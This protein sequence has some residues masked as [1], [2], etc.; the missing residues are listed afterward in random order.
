MAGGNEA[1]L[2]LLSCVQTYL[3][4]LRAVTRARAIAEEEPAV[5]NHSPASS[6]AEHQAVQSLE[7][8]LAR[9]G[10]DLTGM[11]DRR[12]QS[13]EAILARLQVQLL[14]HHMVS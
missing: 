4:F 1:T 11:V 13:M 14:Y 3:F 10:R 7:E 5:A 2:L 9:S 6:G 12:M 8:M